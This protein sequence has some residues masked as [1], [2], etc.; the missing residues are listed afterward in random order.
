MTDAPGTGGASGP[1]GS[2]AEH[3][4]NE[5]ALWGARF[6]SIGSAATDWN[7]S[8]GPLRTTKT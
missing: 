5:G 8:G 1:D 2:T 3:G 4:T 6:A 7:E